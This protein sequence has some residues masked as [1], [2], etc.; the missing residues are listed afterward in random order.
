[1]GGQHLRGTEGQWTTLL[2]NGNHSQQPYLELHPPSQT[3]QHLYIEHDDFYYNNSDEANDF[4]D[5]DDE[6]RNT[7]TD[8]MNTVHNFSISETILKCND[9]YCHNKLKYLEEENRKLR[10]ENED[11]KVAQR[12]MS[13]NCTPG[14]GH[15]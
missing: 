11:L 8:V 4:N 2:T 6:T 1:M 7:I 9:I 3:D 5:I 12:A 15:K 14:M 13:A 10:A